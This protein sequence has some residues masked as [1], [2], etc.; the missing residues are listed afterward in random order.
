MSRTIVAAGLLLAVAAAPAFAQ[1][2]PNRSALAALALSSA[3]VAPTTSETTAAATTDEQ[4]VPALSRPRFGSRT[5]SAVM[6]SLYATTAT[7]QAL[8][9]HSTIR[10]IDRG[11]VEANP[12]MG[13][14]VNNRPAFIATKAAVAAGTIFAAREVAKK[15]KVAAAITLIAINSAY[16]YVAHHNYKLARQLR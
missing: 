16:A 2:V 6:F 11:A 1:D 3:A 13:G 4:Q 8:D 15:N 5:G 12:L 9:V 7:M 14:L 10:A